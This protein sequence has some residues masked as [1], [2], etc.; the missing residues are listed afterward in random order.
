MC[1]SHSLQNCACPKTRSDLNKCKSL[2]FIL[3]SKWIHILWNPFKSIKG[4]FYRQIRKY[5]LSVSPPVSCSKPSQGE[6]CLLRSPTL[7]PLQTVLLWVDGKTSKTVIFLHLNIVHIWQ[8]AHMAIQQIFKWSFGL[9]S[10]FR[11]SH[12]QIE[13]QVY[14]RENK[15]NTHWGM[16]SRHPIEL[17]LLWSVSIVKYYEISI[18]IHVKYFIFIKYY[19]TPAIFLL[20]PSRTPFSIF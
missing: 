3:Y 17:V 4:F 19:I 15:H 16:N 12:K 2:T 18:L 1:S 14:A 11:V 20:E 7:C 10:H 13:M 9:Y 8:W 6:Q 5:C